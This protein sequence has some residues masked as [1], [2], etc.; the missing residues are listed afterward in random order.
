[1]SLNNYERPSL[2]TDIVL[3]RIFNMQSSNT[4]KNA[5]KRLQVLLVERSA[6]P[7]KGKWSLPGG[8]VNIDEEISDNVLR[9]LKEKTGVTGN[10][11]TEQLY[12]WGNID[13]DERG[14]V[15]S[16]SYMGLVKPETYSNSGGTEKQTWMDVEIA[17]QSDL[18]F[19]HVE[20][21]KY[22]IERLK[23][24]MEYTDIVFNLLPDEFTIHD[25]KAIYELLFYKRQD[26]FRRRIEKY[27]EPL[28]KTKTG[29]QFRPAELYKW[30]F[31][32]DSSD[33]KFS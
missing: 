20:I 13:R 15:I 8:F 12:T 7:Q 9:K 14:R 24:K 18:A 26:N 1:M 28:N 29:G 11:Y 16:V 33:G 5:Y 2:T 6:E 31:D 27:V 23:G 21:I 17:L 4:R 32:K 22:A 30:K 3:F 10:F 19:D 25:I